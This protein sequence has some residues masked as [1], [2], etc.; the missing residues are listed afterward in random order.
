MPKTWAN[1]EC[2]FETVN[3]ENQNGNSQ[4]TVTTNGMTRYAPVNRTRAADQ[5]QTGNPNVCYIDPTSNLYRAVMG[6]GDDSMIKILNVDGDSIAVKV[7]GIESQA[8]GRT[9][10]Y[11]VG[12]ARRVPCNGWCPF[13]FRNNDGALSYVHIGHAV[14]NIMPGSTPPAWTR[15]RR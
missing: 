3:T 7:S 15:G 9:V 13:D 2:R 4:Y 5:V 8:G 11:V 12:Q 1:Y 10:N 6:Q 14:R